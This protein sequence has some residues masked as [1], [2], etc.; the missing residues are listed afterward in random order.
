MGDEPSLPGHSRN[1]LTYG[2][3]GHAEGAHQTNEGPDGERMIAA[4]PFDDIAEEREDKGI[5]PGDRS[6]DFEGHPA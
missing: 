4:L 5:G 1:G 3:F 6:L 2:G